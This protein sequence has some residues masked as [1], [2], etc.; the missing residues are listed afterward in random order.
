MRL[1]RNALLVLGFACFVTG[2]L[3]LVLVLIGANL[4]FLTWI[5]KPGSP[6]GIII[7]I[8]LIGGGLMMAYL[9]LN[10]PGDDPDEPVREL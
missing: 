4:S 8:L 1:L 2:M 7:R 5:D 3:S 9:A 6:Q 10:P